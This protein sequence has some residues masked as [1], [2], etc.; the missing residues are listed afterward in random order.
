MYWKIMLDEFFFFP[1][2]FILA[3]R[4]SIC[5]YDFD[6]FDH[7]FIHFPYVLGIWNY[8]NHLFSVH[9]DN[10][11]SPQQLFFHAMQLWFSS[12]ILCLLHAAVCHVFNT[13]NVLG[14]K[15]FMP[16][17]LFRFH[18]LFYRLVMQF[19]KQVGLKSLWW[20]IL[21]QNCCFSAGLRSLLQQNWACEAELLAVSHTLEIARK[22]FWNQLWLQCDSMYMISLF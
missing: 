11:S 9:L 17:L 13:F 4:C 19:E 14:I 18:I 16:I 20:I 3:S 1:K 22:F 6:F 21:M 12:Q 2:G 7:V 15:L 5:K 10:S 8:I